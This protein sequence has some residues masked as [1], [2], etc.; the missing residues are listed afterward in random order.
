M[1]A[2]LNTHHGWWGHMGRRRM[3]KKRVLA[4]VALTVITAPAY[5]ADDCTGQDFSTN[6]SAENSDYKGHVLT[7]FRNANTVTSP[8]SIYNNAIGECSGVM[9]KNPDGK[10]EGMGYCVRNDKDGDTETLRWTL[11]AGATR[12]T[13]QMIGGTGKFAKTQAHHG[14]WEGSFSDGKVSINNWGGNCR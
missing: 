11:P 8:N 9:L 4:Y 2:L 7:V 13:W 6:L 10:L 5:A 3:M 14:W 1:F 12:G